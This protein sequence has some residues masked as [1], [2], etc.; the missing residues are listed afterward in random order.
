[1]QCFVQALDSCACKAFS[2]HWSSHAKNR[3]GRHVHIKPTK[4]KTCMYTVGD[5]KYDDVRKPR[6]Q[7]P[8]LT[9]N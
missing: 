6:D 1:M 4:I 9:L 3:L 2:G 8:I 7:L 5:K